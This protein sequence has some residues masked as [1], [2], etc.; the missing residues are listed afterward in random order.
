MEA[1]KAT[2]LGYVDTQQNQPNQC[3]AQRVYGGGDRNEGGWAKTGGDASLC[4]LTPTRIDSNMSS[5]QDQIQGDITLLNRVLDKLAL[6][7]EGDLQSL[8]AR[9][10]VAVLDKLDSPHEQVKNKVFPHSLS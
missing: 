10:L 1:R 7:N 5:S 6:A 9:F 4:S 8:L 3:P 2:V